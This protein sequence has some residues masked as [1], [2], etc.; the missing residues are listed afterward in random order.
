M[1]VVNIA[2]VED[3]ADV[4]EGWEYI[5]AQTDGL[6]C[7]GSFPTGEN[8]LADLETGSP[9]VVLMDIQLPG[10]S[11]IQCIKQAKEKCPSLQCIMLTVFDDQDSIFQALSAGATGYLLKTASPGM[12]VNAVREVH[13]GESPMSGSIARKVIQYFQQPSASIIPKESEKSDSHRD[14][15]TER[16]IEIVQRLSDGR[17]YKEIANDLN[18]SMDTVRSHIRNVYEKL[19]VRNRTEAVNKVFRP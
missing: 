2:L 1:K 4:R 5:L 11:G 9:D 16:E 8:F 10:M 6:Q 3:D 13:R 15:L 14:K 19:Q 12:L 7:T 17:L 18:I